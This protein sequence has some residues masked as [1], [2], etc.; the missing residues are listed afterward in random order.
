FEKFDSS[1][2]WYLSTGKCVD[3]ELFLSGLQC[4]YDHPARSL[5]MDP[6]DKNFLLYN[7]FTH[8]ELKEIAEYKEQK[9]LKNNNTFSKAFDPEE[10]WV[11]YT[12]YSL[13]REY[14][15]GNLDCKH[16]EAW[17]QSHSWS[18]I[19]TCFDTVKGLEAVIR[20]PHSFA[21]RKRKSKD[22]AISSLQATPRMTYGHRYDLVF[23]MYDV[24]HSVP[25]E[26]GAS[27]AGAKDED[28][29]G[30]KFINEGFYKLPRVL[31]NM[32]DCLLER[33]NFDQRSTSV[34]TVGFLH[35]GLAARLS[36][37]Y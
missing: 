18:M 22:R 10:D 8:A 28:T 29:V 34:R 37:K 3:D 12:V 36:N 20:K 1:K 14:E 9:L 5:M 2:K 31:R 16:K 35:A 7:V 11:I 24:G 17:Y 30:T 26:F 15:S 27:E 19:E 13:L 4:N 33:V 32:L 25:Y 6:D 23:R 21:I